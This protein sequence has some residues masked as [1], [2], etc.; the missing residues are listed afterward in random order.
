MKANPLISIPSINSTSAQWIE[1]HKSLKAMV[2]VR[3]A[4]QTWLYAWNK[5]KTDNANDGTLRNY[6]DKQGVKIDPDGLLEEVSDTIG[7]VFGFFG[8][9]IKI[10]SYAVGAMVLFPFIIGG[11]I[12]ISA[13]RNPKKTIELA[14][15]ATP[16]GRAVG[17]ASAVSKSLKP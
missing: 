16:Q 3:T 7:G 2:G 1:W 9:V 4:N 6:M 14:S 13:L 5:R 11:V 12:I 15:M 8:N 17:A 10:G